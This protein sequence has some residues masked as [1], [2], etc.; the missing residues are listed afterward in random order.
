MLLIMKP[1]ILMTGHTMP[2]LA[3]RR[4]D[5]DT[6]YARACGV[7]VDRFHVVD[8]VGGAPLPNPNSIDALIVS[9]SPHCVKNYDDWSVKAG[10]FMKTAVSAGV[11]TL[12]ICYG[13]QLLADELGGVVGVNPN[14][15][16]IGVSLVRQYGQDALFD[17]LASEFTVIQTHV[18]AVLE[19]PQS[20][21][22]IAGNAN[23]ANQ[24]MRVRQQ[25]RTVQWHPEFDIDII[26]HYL[27]ARAEQIDSELGAGAAKLFKDRLEPVS[28]G[29]VI[30][31]NFFAHI[32][33]RSLR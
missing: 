11:P 30:M 24:A 26:A 32:V 7:T 2:E 6:W 21:T 27:D 16:E 23:T 14:G 28:S 17:G 8:A 12:G 25:V 15:R 3:A 5:Y 20:T 22:V 31:D 10:E 4:G 19:A 1:V 18:D 33:G 13:H 29:T 9:G